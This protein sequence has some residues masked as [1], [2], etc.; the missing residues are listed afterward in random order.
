MKD[1]R[2]EIKKKRSAHVPLLETSKM[3]TKPRRAGVLEMADAASKDNPI[4]IPGPESMGESDDR[5]RLL[6]P[7]DPLLF[8][9]YCY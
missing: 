6:L 3:E 5:R 2:G 4:L 7:K 9:H 8:Y 1:L